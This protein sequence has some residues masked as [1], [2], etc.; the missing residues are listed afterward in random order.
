MFTSRDGTALRWLLFKCP[1]ASAKGC[2]SRCFPNLLHRTSFLDRPF[3]RFPV[4]W[5]R[6]RQILFPADQPF[7]II[8]LAIPLQAM[9]AYIICCQTDPVVLLVLQASSRSMLQYLAQCRASKD[10]WSGGRSCHFP[11]SRGL[12]TVSL[13]HAMGFWS[14]ARHVHDSVKY[15]HGRPSAMSTMPTLA[16]HHHVTSP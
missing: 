8:V 7:G 2:S 10:I 15:R 5:L 11:R 9:L 14:K 12:C 13:Q 16:R 1:A 6:N 4:V 3:G